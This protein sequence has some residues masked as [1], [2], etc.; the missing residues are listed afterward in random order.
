[1][2]YAVRCLQC[3]KVMS[4]EVMCSQWYSVHNGIRI[5][6]RNALKLSIIKHYP[7]N[8]SIQVQHGARNTCLTLTFATYSLYK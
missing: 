6:A 2:C 7:G 4:N 8:Y 5:L 1:M 3:Y